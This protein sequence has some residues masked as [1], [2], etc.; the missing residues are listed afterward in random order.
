[1]SVFNSNSQ[2]DTMFFGGDLGIARYDVVKYPAIEKLT[3]KQQGMFWLPQEVELSKD[4]KDFK[5]LSDVEKHIFTSNLKRQILLDSVQGRGPS[6]ALGPI[7]SLPEVEA[8]IKT[9]EF[10]ETIHSRSYTHIIRNVYNDP[11][12]VLNGIMEIKEIVDCAKD[13]S[14]YYD[15]LI[16]FNIYSQRPSLDTGWTVFDEHEHKVRLWMCLNAINVLEGIRFYGS[17]VCSWIFAEQNK[18]TGN[19]TI[20]KFIARDEN[21]HLAFTQQLLKLLPKDDPDFIAIKE[22]CK[23][24]VLKMVNSV[25]EQEKAWADYLFQYGSI[26]GMNADI[27]KSYVDYIAGKRMTAIGIPNNKPTDNPL[28]WS[29]RWI[30]GSDVQV[31]PQE[32]NLTSYVI[33]GFKNDLEQDSFSGISL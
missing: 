33:G 11:S 25:V 16:K 9:W 19:A 29:N 21:I 28:P 20:I 6:A 18:M 22:D 14:S 2:S 23:D 27:L 13:I 12:V 1:M 5:Q 31:L 32:E 3:V 10:F 7:T 4:A 26:L 8:F 17:F 15:A 30:A 24:E